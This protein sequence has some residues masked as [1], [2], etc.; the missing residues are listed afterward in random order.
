MRKGGKPMNR[1]QVLGR[2]GHRELVWDLEISIT[3][4]ER[5]YLTEIGYV[6]GDGRW[7]ML[8]RSAPLWIR[9]N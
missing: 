8:A 1:L 2:D 5:R 6:T 4:T 7:L 3:Q 9:A